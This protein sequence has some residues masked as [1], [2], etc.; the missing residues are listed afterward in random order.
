VLF[1]V[2]K[3]KWVKI[4]RFLLRCFLV[5]LLLGGLFL[6]VAFLPGEVEG[7]YRGIASSCGCD[8]ITFTN[9]RGGKMITYHSAHPPAWLSGRYQNANGVVE[10]YLD[11]LQSK[12]AESLLMRAYPRFLITKFVDES[13]GKQYWCW[14]WPALGRIGEA[15]RRQEVSAMRIGEDGVMRR[16]VFDCDLKRVRS[17]IKIGPNQ[18]AEQVVP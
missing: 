2:D 16:N 3:M 10:L 11:G 13:E 5:F 7:N 17:E 1:D 8:G 4:R 12:E 6:G 18:W 15:L 9:L 14:K